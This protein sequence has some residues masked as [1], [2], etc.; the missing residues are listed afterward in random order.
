MATKTKRR[1]KT[2]IV[3]VAAPL[4]KRAGGRRVNRSNMGAGG[5]TSELLA[6]A[7]LGWAQ[8][9]GM[10]ARIPTLGVLGLEGTIAVGGYLWARNGGPKLAGTI[11]RVAGIVAANHLGR[12]G[13]STSGTVSGSSSYDAGGD[14]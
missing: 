2:Q 11:G 3:R 13:L 6:A 10:L 5:M 14:Y 12:T 9:A 4:A 1:P 8:R 7:A